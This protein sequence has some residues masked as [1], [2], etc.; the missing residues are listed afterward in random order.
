MHDLRVIYVNFSN[1]NMCGEFLPVCSGTDN[2]L[3][4]ITLL[5]TCNPVFHLVTH[6]FPFCKPSFS[7]YSRPQTLNRARR[8]AEPPSCHACSFL[9]IALQPEVLR[10]QTEPPSRHSVFALWPIAG[11]L[12][13]F[14]VLLISVLSR[15]YS[16]DSAE[17]YGS[18]P[19]DMAELVCGKS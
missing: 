7:F 18:W 2:P 19:S 8:Q 14:L 6:L 5:G 12:S 16:C 3:A 1:F 17:W 11:T 9:L 15:T 10:R 13:F 4:I